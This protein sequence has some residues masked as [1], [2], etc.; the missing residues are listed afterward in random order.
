[1]AEFRRFLLVTGHDARIAKGNWQVDIVS[2]D[3]LKSIGNPA[4]YDGWILNTTALQTR[5]VRKI[6]TSEEL[7][8]LF[9]YRGFIAVMQASGR[10]FIIGDFKT[11]FYVPASTGGGGAA[12]KASSAP[13]EQQFNIF[14]KM[15]NVERDPR[16]VD[17]RRIS[18][19]DD[20]RYREYYAYLD[21]VAAWNYSLNSRKMRQISR[22]WSLVQQIS[23]RVWQRTFP[24]LPEVS[25]YCLL[26]ESLWKRKTDMFYNTF[27]GLAYTL[28]PL[29][30]R[31]G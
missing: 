26:W 11:A 28:R 29:P 15:L 25:F 16:P 14:E 5:P 31:A 19:P 17:Y 21:K 3:S 13:R 9:D 30:G 8:V 1:M 20:Y 23:G 2:W 10:I 24:C 22:P 18:R 6:F 12:P 27:S 4:D 7:N